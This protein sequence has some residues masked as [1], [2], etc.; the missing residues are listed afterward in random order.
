MWKYIEL[1]ENKSIVIINSL[2]RSSYMLAMA[3]TE[4]MMRLLRDI[5]RSLCIYKAKEREKGS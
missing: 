2:V 4:L 3:M 5:R 1:T